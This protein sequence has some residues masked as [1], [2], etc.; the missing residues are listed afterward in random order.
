MYT[1]RLIDL[2]GSIKLSNTRE[3]PVCKHMVTY[4]SVQV[5]SNKVDAL[6]PRRL[7][8]HSIHAQ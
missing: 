5:H 3:H 7:I 4:S 1:N 6:G 2:K 8:M